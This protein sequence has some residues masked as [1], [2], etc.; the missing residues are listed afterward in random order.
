M[1]KAFLKG[2]EIAQLFDSERNLAHAL[3]REGKADSFEFFVGEPTR[4]RHPGYRRAYPGIQKEIAP[5]SAE[6]IKGRIETIK[7]P[8]F[9]A[10]LFGRFFKHKKVCDKALL[11]FENGEGKNNEESLS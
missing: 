9:F 6:S 1:I 11:L 10:Q 3:V 8:G 5:V 2:K 4:T 7:K